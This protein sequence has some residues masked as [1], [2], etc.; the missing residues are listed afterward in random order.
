MYK[1]F[2]PWY[3][4][5]EFLTK[6]INRKYNNTSFMI[7][8]LLELNKDLLSMTSDI[9]DVIYFNIGSADNLHTT[10]ENTIRQFPEFLCNYEKILVILVDN[11]TQQ[12]E[13]LQLFPFEEIS[14]NKYQYENITVWIYKTFIPTFLNTRSTILPKEYSRG[15]IEEQRNSDDKLFVKEF[16]NNLNMFLSRSTCV[17]YIVNCATFISEFAC[18]P[19]LN[20]DLILFPEIKQLFSEKIKVLIWPNQ[21]HK[22]FIYGSRSCIDYI[23]DTYDSD[24]D[25]NKNNDITVYYR[26][27]LVKELH[28]RI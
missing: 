28:S 27:Q 3:F 22:F 26:L 19:G 11:F 8:Q 13:I 16:Y 5:G 4:K 14:C 2:Y 24:L 18:G 25:K 15:I 12:P 7:N 1:L 6:M 20:M 9:Y 17:S 23:N 21:S 10:Y